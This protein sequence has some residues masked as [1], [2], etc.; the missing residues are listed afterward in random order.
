M[1]NIG[2]GISYR[3]RAESFTIDYGVTSGGW[4]EIITNGYTRKE[5]GGVLNA[6]INYLIWK[7]FN[8]GIYS[9]IKLYPKHI[10]TLYPNTITH[11][12]PNSISYG[13]SC[14]FNF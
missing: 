11:Q 14:G 9:Q 6:D 5:F 4:S 2:G 8:L 13:V 7:R 10:E 1:I 12:S 3:K